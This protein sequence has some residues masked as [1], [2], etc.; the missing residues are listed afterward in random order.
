MS[1]IWTPAEWCLASKSKRKET[2]SYY[3]HLFLEVL[4]NTDFFFLFDKLIKR[5]IS[6]PSLVMW[7]KMRYVWACRKIII[8]G[9]SIL[10]Y[11]L[12][13]STQTHTLSCLCSINLMSVIILTRV[14]RTQCKQCKKQKNTLFCSP[15]LFANNL[16]GSEEDLWRKKAV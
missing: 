16:K 5:K 8:L 12:N 1:K 13:W 10:L 15:A 2:W 4:Q 3:C 6:P 7:N 9:I 14:T 11:K